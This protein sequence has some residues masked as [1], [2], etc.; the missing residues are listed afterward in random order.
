MHP[1]DLQQKAGTSNFV[2]VLLLKVAL[3]CSGRYGQLDECHDCWGSTSEG[4]VQVAVTRHPMDVQDVDGHGEALQANH[5]H[6]RNE[7]RLLIHQAKA[8]Q[9]VTQGLDHLPDSKR[10]RHTRISVIALPLGLELPEQLHVPVSAELNGPEHFCLSARNV[11]EAA[12]GILS[13][14]EPILLRTL[15]SCWLGAAASRAA[16]L[17]LLPGI[18]RDVFREVPGRMALL[19][20]VG[21]L[22]YEGSAPHLH[23]LLLKVRIPGIQDIHLRAARNWQA[24]EAGE[25][26]RAIAVRRN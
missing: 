10:H 26:P 18:V 12:V 25:Q 23:T 21:L 8:H 6:V 17:L 14:T 20:R 4:Q 7:D 15:A 22:A 1:A 16:L 13:L 5:Q 9:V 11:V 19:P 24:D 3:S 2:G